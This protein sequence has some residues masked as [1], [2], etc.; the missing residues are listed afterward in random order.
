ML[1]TVTLSFYDVNMVRN[2][3]VVI[4]DFTKSQIARDWESFVVVVVVVVHLTVP[5]YLA[6]RHLKNRF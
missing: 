3:T 1:F 5:F 6:I 2:A 4:I